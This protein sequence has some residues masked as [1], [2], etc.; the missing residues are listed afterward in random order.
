MTPLSPTMQEALE[1]V[2]NHGSIHRHPGGYWNREGDHS[3]TFTGGFG[4]STI[5]ALVKR[6]HLTYTE[7]KEGR[8]GRFPIKAEVV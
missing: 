8:N 7:W 4:A 2:K 5:N 3:F 6:G 1:F